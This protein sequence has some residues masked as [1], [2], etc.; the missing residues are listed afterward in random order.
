MN[1]NKIPVLKC[2]R[3][4]HFCWWDGDYVCF[5][6]MKLLAQAPNGSITRAE[7][8]T[9]LKRYRF[10]GYFKKKNYLKREQKLYI[11]P[12]KLIDDE[13]R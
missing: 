5:E 12:E 8:D 10:C 2:L 13:K 1:S 7:Y 11:V 9:L 6:D 3:C 4:E